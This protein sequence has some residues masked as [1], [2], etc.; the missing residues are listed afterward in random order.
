[1]IPLSKTETELSALLD[2]TLAL[3]RTVKGV[4]FD[5]QKIRLMI[6]GRA[7]NG[8]DKPTPDFSWV[9]S[10]FEEAHGMT[11]SQFWNTG[12]KFFSALT[13]ITLEDDWYENIVWTNLFR[14]AP[15]SGGNPTKK[16]ADNQKRLC[17]QAHKEDIETYQPTHILYMTGRNWMCDF[18]PE[19]THSPM[20]IVESYGIIGDSIIVVLPH[21]QTKRQDVCVND[22]IRAIEKMKGK[23]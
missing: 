11:R 14:I 12:K 19:L 4:R 22:A 8:T 1:M 17:I 2:E 3:F 7:T 23:C 20:G 9:R 5:S 10:Y 15:K 18:Q 16:L 6:V 21:P 13:G